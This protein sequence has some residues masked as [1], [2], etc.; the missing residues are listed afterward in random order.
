M[1]FHSVNTAGVFKSVEQS[2]GGQKIAFARTPKVRNRTVAPLSFVVIP[3]VIVALSAWT[4]W[5]DLQLN[6]FTHAL[7]AGSNA[8]LTL[9]A[10]VAFVGIR[11]SLADTRVNL[12]E[13]LYVQVQTQEV[14][15]EPDWDPVLH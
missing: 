10:V 9:Y 7:F 6:Q 13:R 1:M 3:Y 4:L 8:M 5:R 14:E 2:I 12:M 15:V 11:Y